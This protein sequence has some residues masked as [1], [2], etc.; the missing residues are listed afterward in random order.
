MDSFN[1]SNLNFNDDTILNR[2][3][4][5]LGEIGNQ[6]SSPSLI[7]T[8]N[9]QQM[10]MSKSSYLNQS[11]MSRFGVSNHQPIDHDSSRLNFT[12]TFDDQQSNYFSKRFF[13]IDFEF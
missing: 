6:H 2:T 5:L 3:R 10:L 7:R 12:Q 11:T 8:P 13:I 4:M 1:A 9:S